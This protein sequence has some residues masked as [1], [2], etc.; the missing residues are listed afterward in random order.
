[1]ELKNLT[2]QQLLEKI[3]GLLATDANV[4]VTTANAAL[5]T[6]QEENARLSAT[7][8]K[9]PGL[10]AEVGRLN[11]DLNELQ[12]MVLELNT[13]LVAQVSGKVSGGN[14]PI[15]KS[16]ALT[17]RIHHGVTH[18]GRRYT[19]QQIADTP[20]VLD[21]LVRLGGSEIEILHS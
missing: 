13:R 1:M 17:V 12:A 21:E 14:K 7:A 15:A 6:A 5:A 2:K 11:A 19:P 18:K 3:E 8:E 10:E 4:A 9:V 16:G 20:A